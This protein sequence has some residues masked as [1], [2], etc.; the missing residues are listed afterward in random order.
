MIGYITMGTNDLEKAVAFYDAL[1]A[2]IGAGRFMQVR[3][4]WAVLMWLVA[5]LR[6]VPSPRDNPPC[7]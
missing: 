7:R 1:L 5:R 2:V 3:S 6:H 4:P